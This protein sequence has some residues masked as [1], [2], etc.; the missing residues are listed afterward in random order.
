MSHQFLLIKFDE[1]LKSKI[2]FKT[3][4]FNENCHQ[5]MFCLESEKQR[6]GGECI[7]NLIF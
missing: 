7:F 6:R 5:L 4:F 3:I 2:W 1:L